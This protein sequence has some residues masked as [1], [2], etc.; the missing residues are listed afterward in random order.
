MNKQLWQLSY[1]IKEFYPGAK[2]YDIEEE[3]NRIKFFVEGEEDIDMLAIMDKCI[4]EV[5]FKY[6]A[7]G[8]W[9]YHKHATFAQ[10]NEVNEVPFL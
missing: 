1:L 7:E 10:V 4:K 6:F 5:I 8:E 9:C 3:E 2:V